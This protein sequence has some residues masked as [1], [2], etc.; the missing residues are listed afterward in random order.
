MNDTKFDYASYF[1]D[2]ISLIKDIFSVK[3]EESFL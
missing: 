2:H 1:I 3:I